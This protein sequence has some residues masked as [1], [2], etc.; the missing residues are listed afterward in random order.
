MTA[1]PLRRTTLGRALAGLFLALTC[2]PLVACA[3]PTG[4]PSA[5]ETS[6][7]ASD[8]SP[9]AVKLDGP[10][11]AGLGDEVTV[12]LTNVGRLPDAYQL[13][14]EPVGAARIAEANITASPQES[15]EV[16]V[17]IKD[18]PVTIVVKSVGGV[19]GRPIGQLTIN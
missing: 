10:E 11:N 9:Y 3:S 8:A 18:T 13:S 1:S 4:E 17:T 15:V 19:A 6:A 5:P 12:T 7:G 2:A 14:A 16:K